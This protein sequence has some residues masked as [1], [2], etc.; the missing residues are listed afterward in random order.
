M[1]TYEIIFKRH[2]TNSSSAYNTLKGTKRKKMKEIQIYCAGIMDALKESENDIMKGWRDEAMDY[3]SLHNARILS[4]LR[5][6]H[7]D[8]STLT[9]REIFEL[10]LI[11]VQNCDLV[12]ADCSDYGKPQFGTP[13]EIFYC[14]HILR[15]PVIGFYKEEYGVRENSI[16]QNVLVT[17]MFKGLTPALD[18]ISNYYLT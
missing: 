6:P 14:N 7:S 15:K 18:H 4:P 11:D 16:F 13:V 12:L 1:F 8:D 10:D 9:P 3:F 5:R 2:L 17:N